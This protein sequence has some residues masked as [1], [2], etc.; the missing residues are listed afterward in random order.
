MHLQPIYLNHTYEVVHTAGHTHMH[1]YDRV[2][3]LVSQHQQ[4]RRG[5]AYKWEISEFFSPPLLSFISKACRCVCVIRCRAGC[6]VQT[7]GATILIYPRVFIIELIT[8]T[9]TNDNRLHIY[10]LG[11]SLRF[12]TTCVYK[13]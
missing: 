4:I 1:T 13:H 8:S 3:G 7:A 11:I 6:I 2:E 12:I 10:K 9:I 5:F